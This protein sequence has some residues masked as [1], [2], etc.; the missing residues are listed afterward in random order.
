MCIPYGKMFTLKDMLKEH[1]C[2]M[3]PKH[4]RCMKCLKAFKDKPALILVSP[5]SYFS[6]TDSHFLVQHLT[7]THRIF[8]CILCSEHVEKGVCSF[9]YFHMWCFWLLPSTLRLHTPNYLV[10]YVIWYFK[11]K[12]QSRSIIQNLHNICTMI[13]A[14]SDLQTMLHIK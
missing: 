5:D 10:A 3:L 4:Q 12:N 2:E 14:I 13:V 11:A 7:S 6:F 9:P 8:F 1:Y